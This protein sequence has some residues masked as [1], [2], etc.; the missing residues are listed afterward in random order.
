[1]TAQPSHATLGAAAES[2]RLI[3]DYASGTFE[4]YDMPGLETKDSITPAHLV[5]ELFQPA[6]TITRVISQ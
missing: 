2:S 4:E 6:A 5:F 3:R 1:V